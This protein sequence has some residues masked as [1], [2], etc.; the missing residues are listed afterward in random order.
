MDNSVIIACPSRGGWTQQWVA[1]LGAVH[2]RSVNPA[3]E[4]TGA[5]DITAKCWM[6]DT[7][8]L[9]GR[10]GSVESD[11]VVIATIDLGEIEAKHAR[12]AT[13]DAASQTGIAEADH[14]LGQAPLLQQLQRSR[15]HADGAGRPKRLRQLIH[16][17]DANAEAGQFQRRGQAG[18]SGTNDQDRIRHGMSPCRNYKP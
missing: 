9:K 13:V 18:R 17:T 15:L 12:A 1:R 4:T 5:D 7:E 10:P 2:R 6:A 16:D 14:L 11:G 3:Y 8:D